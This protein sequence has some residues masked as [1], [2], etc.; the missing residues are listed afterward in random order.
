MPKVVFVTNVVPIYRYP[1]F[2][3]L[4]RATEFRIQ[5]LVTVPLSVSCPEAVANLSMKY[6]VS[7]NVLRTTHHAASGALQR[8]PFSIPFA[9]IINLIRSRPDV[10]VAGDFGLR[11]AIC[12]SAAR[13]LGCR[14]VLSSEEIATSAAGRS[15]LQQWLRRFLVRRAD[16]FLAWG[17]P[18]RQLLVS[19]NAGESRIF[20][21]AQAIDNEFWVRQAQSLDR[22]TERKS[23]GLNGVA[24][25]LVGRA[26]A[27]KGFQNFLDAWSRLPQELH[28]RIC[29]VIIG[30]G[31]YLE[32]LK[33]AAAAR[34]LRNVS[35]AG[36]KSAAQLARFYAAADIFVYPSL[37]DVWGLVVNE[38]MCFGLPILASQFAGASQ[39]LVAGS[40]VGLVF[41]P[42]DI[43]AFAVKL[44]EW[45]RQPPAPAPE[46][47]RQILK[48]VTF[49]RSRQAIERMV[50]DVT[51]RPGT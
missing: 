41:N 11:S 18:A 48:N 25:L 43:D 38:A 27:R 37:E 46:A 39:S 47:C 16:A 10:I 17:D 30:D 49:D 32:H 26:L 34:G 42:A 6:S 19:M 40:N 45:A 12:W 21:C 8:E 50:A 36:A 22:Q 24:F 15:R 13:L 9:L 28:E 3:Q 4:A 7:L 33:S 29:A 44:G 35:F 5:I 31:D 14:F 2:E 20:G 1:I 51:A 23:L